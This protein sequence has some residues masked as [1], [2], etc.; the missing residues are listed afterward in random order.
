MPYHTGYGLFCVGIVQQSITG[1]CLDTVPGRCIQL[2]EIYGIVYIG[3]VT[4]MSMGTVP[5]GCMQIGGG[6]ER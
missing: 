5:G 4:G 3:L 6:W 1:R 2:A